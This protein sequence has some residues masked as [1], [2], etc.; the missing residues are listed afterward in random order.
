MQAGAAV[1]L[2]HD[3]SDRYSLCLFDPT[4]HQGVIGILAS[5]IREAHHRPAIAFARGED[6]E[7]K[8]SGRS[9]GALH[10]RDALYLIG[11]RLPG[12]IKKFGGHAMAAGLTIAEE[13]F[14]AFAVEFE[15]VCRELL[16]ES[17]LS[18]VIETDGS[19]A[20]EEITYALACEL[21]D[22]V[23]GQ[24]FASPLFYDEFE[25]DSQRIVGEKHL[26][27]RLTKRDTSF[28]AML[29]FA[30]DTLPPRIRGAYQLG[31]NQYNG[32][33][34]LQ[35]TLEYWEACEPGP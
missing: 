32:L 16:D 6:G 35:L 15:R 21:G 24:G 34:S 10:L 11:E 26:K 31:V 22:G 23:W 14:E 30:T 9:I 29:F 4:W 7:L 3:T 1:Q 2:E 19:L 18:E 13:N 5:R 12:M 8:G 25:V 33:Q 27:L 20:A 28:D 17:D